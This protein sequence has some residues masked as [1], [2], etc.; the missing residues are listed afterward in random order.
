MPNPHWPQQLCQIRTF[1][2]ASDARLAKDSSMAIR[3]KRGVR[4]VRIRDI[5]DN[6]GIPVAERILVIHARSGCDTVSATFGHGKSVLLKMV[7]KKDDARNLVDIF[8]CDS[9]SSAEVSEAGAKLF[10]LM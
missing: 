9:V 6:I 10:V 4:F 3:S 8:M 2:L 7:Q 1:V 5:V